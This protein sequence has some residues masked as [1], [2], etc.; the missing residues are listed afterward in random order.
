MEKG[1]LLSLSSCYW[2]GSEEVPVK[3]D[4]NSGWWSP[5]QMS[6]NG[7][8]SCVRGINRDL[9]G[10]QGGNVQRRVRAVLRVRSSLLGSQVFLFKK[11]FCAILGHFFFIIWSI[12]SVGKVPN[13]IDFISPF[14]QS[15]LRIQGWVGSL[16]VHRV[17]FVSGWI[18]SNFKVRSEDL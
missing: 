15:S 3:G 11:K 14:A 4:L 17:V 2:R 10:K 13:I 8:L 9:L 12:D 16:T 18:C 1:S 5:W 6:Q 7:I